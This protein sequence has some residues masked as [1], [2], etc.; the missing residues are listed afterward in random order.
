[1]LPSEAITP[2]PLYS[3]H[4]TVF[5]SSTRTNP[6]GPARNEVSQSPCASEVAMNAI[7]IRAMNSRI[8]GVRWSSTWLS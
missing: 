8:S 6:G 7:R 4:I 5:S 1:M 3:G 2:L